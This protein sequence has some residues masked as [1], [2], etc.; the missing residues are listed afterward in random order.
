LKENVP[1]IMQNQQE[2]TKL[3]LK[4]TPIASFFAHFIDRIFLFCAIKSH[5]FFNARNEDKKRKICRWRRKKE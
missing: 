4:K 5:D 1:Y 2:R 3:W